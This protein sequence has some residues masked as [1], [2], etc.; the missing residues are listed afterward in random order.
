LGTWDLV[1]KIHIMV[2]HLLKFGF[3]NIKYNYKKN[4]YT[5]YGYLQATN[6]Y[7][8]SSESSFYI[9]VNDFVGSQS[10]QILLLGNKSTLISENVLSRV[11]I[12]NSPFQNNIYSSLQNYSI[13]RNYNGVVR[14]RKLHIKIID[15]HGR[16]VN[17]QDYPTNFVFE[18]TTQYSSEKFI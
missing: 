14:I 6:I 13:K 1:L 9:S 5:Y 2:H 7:G 4:I 16:L 8:H 15:V 12:T 3:N 17:L 11:Q 18:F 10:Q